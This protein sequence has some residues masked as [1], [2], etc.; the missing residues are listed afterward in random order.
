[1]KEFIYSRNAV[2]EVLRAKRRDV[3][4]IMIA[5][6]VQ[7]K[8]K[9]KEI[10]D[11]ALQRKIKATRVPRGRL[12]KIHENHQ[13]VVADVGAYPYS[14]VIEILDHAREKSEPPFLLILD[15]LQDPQNFGT[16]LR[17]AEAVGVHGIV[18]PLARTVEVTPAVVNASSGASEHLLIAQANLAQAMDSLKDA[19]LWMVGLDQHGVKMEA[20]SRHLRG[21]LGLVVGSEGEGLRE[22]TRKK[23]DIILQLPMRG[24][25]ESLNAAVAGSVALYMAYLAR[26][27]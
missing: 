21:A 23:C 22:L 8:G 14:D 1:M 3:F 10:I 4:E 16:L 18:I 26:N 25:I 15:S 7:E 11:S 6:G 2:Y 9:I 12:D 20:G 19:E 5:E 24:K 13:G 27:V 17:T